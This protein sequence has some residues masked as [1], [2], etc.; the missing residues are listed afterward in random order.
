MII[1]STYKKILVLI[2]LALLS[3]CATVENDHDPLE[4]TN[5]KV[6]S[7]NDG[8]DRATLKPIAK[9]YTAITNK[10][11]RT[12]ISNFYDNI[13]YLNT[14]LNDFLQ[15]KGQQGVEDISRFAINSTIGVA[16]FFD[17]ATEF[18]L[19]KHDEDFGQTLATWGVSKGAYLVYPL[20]G[21]N[22]ARKTP[23]LVTSVATDPLFWLSFAIA[24]VITIPLTAMK[25]VDK[26]SRLLDASD[27][28]DELALDPY[29]FTRDAWRQ[30]REFLIHDGHPP[31][32]QADDDD[33]DDEDFD[34]EEASP[35]EEQE[36]DTDN[37]KN[38]SPQPAPEKEYRPRIRFS[39][40]DKATGKE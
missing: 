23:D 31:A 16:G 30:N 20:L 1:S 6:E 3:G 40:P 9:G 14:I 21:P 5:R 37:S 27:M 15:G 17:P 24:P 13:T 10:H 22:S 4:N 26:R 29:I 25:Y 32:Q 34:S 33:W 18:G 19:E 28:R 2:V 39:Y 12:A 8:V 11:I 38:A 7:F 35:V 36:T